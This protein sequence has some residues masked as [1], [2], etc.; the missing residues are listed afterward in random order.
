MNFNYIFTVH[1][2][3]KIFKK[4]KTNCEDTIFN[5]F[6]LTNNAINKKVMSHINITLNEFILLLENN[7]DS[8][9]SENFNSVTSYKYNTLH[10][11]TF[12]EQC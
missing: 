4:I 5:N 7:T 9:I 2:D 8:L 11:L 10:L 1:K 6:I 12:I 3:N